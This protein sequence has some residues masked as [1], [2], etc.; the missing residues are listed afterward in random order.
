M[1]WTPPVVSGRS[2]RPAAPGSVP[3]RAARPGPVARGPRLRA[4]HSADAQSRR[5]R[6]RRHGAQ[7]RRQAVRQSAPVCRRRAPGEVRSV[8]GASEQP[9]ARAQ[10]DRF[11]AR[12]LRPLPPGAGS[13]RSPDLP[14]RLAPRASVG[15]PHGGRPGEPDGSP[16]RWH[17]LRSQPASS[18]LHG[19]HGGAAAGPASADLHGQSIEVRPHGRARLSATR[20]SRRRDQSSDGP[21][22]IGHLNL[23]AAV[24]NTTQDSARLVLELTHPN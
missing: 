12:A 22:P 17:R 16:T 13:V 6:R 14:R 7:S 2:A 5:T 3:R 23:L 8:V 11:A 21:S 10:A 18:F 4:G 24:P 20:P 15:S 19:P 9:G 1:D